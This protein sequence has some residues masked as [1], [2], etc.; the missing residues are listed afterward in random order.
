[1]TPGLKVKF[2]DPLCDNTYHHFIPK[3]KVKH[4]KIIDISEEI[5]K[6]QNNREQNYS[7]FSEI[8]F[9]QRAL[10]YNAKIL[11]NPYYVEITTCFSNFVKRVDIAND[12]IKDFLHSNQN[13]GVSETFV[14]SLLNSNIISKIENHTPI[15]LFKEENSFYKVFFGSESPN[16]DQ[17]LITTIANPTHYKY[18]PLNETDFLYVQTYEE[19]KV[20]WLLSRF[21]LKN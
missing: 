16:A 8:I 7:Q 17:G 18:K 14:R 11:E 13:N 2:T 4:N 12:L 20:L 15:Q 6:E 9:S 21:Y 5:L 3:L 10:A 19:W 1:M